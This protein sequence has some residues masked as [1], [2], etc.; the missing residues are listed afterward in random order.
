VK[1][2]SIDEPALP[3]PP[4]PPC[5]ALGSAI[6]AAGSE[7][8]HAAIATGDAKVNQDK[9]LIQR[10]QGSPEGCLDPLLMH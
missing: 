10:L 2:P 6:S 8:E 9:L 7:E 4:A 1:N 5:E 3:L